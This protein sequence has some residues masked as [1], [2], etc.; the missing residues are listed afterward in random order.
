MVYSFN[1]F[2]TYVCTVHGAGSHAYRLRLLLVVLWYSK[3]TRKVDLAN[4]GMRKPLFPGDGAEDSSNQ[5]TTYYVFIYM[6]TL[7]LLHFLIHLAPSFTRPMIL[8]HLPA[9]HDK[10]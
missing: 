4:Q 10:W 9:E 2:S 5:V 6:F 1:M 8:R 7:A 3:R